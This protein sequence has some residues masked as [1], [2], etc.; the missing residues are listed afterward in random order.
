MI[1]DTGCIIAQFFNEKNFVQEKFPIHKNV[2]ENTIAYG[3]FSLSNPGGNFPCLRCFFIGQSGL[4]HGTSKNR[5]PLAIQQSKLTASNRTIK[6]KRCPGLP[7][8]KS[9]FLA[10]QILLYE[11]IDFFASLIMALRRIGA[12]GTVEVF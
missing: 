11:R 12:S 10:L 5:R 8:D 4:L 3:L 1:E 7:M 6:E 9:H 2:R